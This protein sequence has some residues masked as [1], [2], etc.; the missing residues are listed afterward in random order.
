M[1]K[2]HLW[3]AIHRAGLDIVE[4]PDDGCLAQADT[5]VWRFEC[6][7]FGPGRHL[8]ATRHLPI[9]TSLLVLLGLAL[10]QRWR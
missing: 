6:H 4:W 10:R 7:D 8:L 9:L 5:L 2:D 1:P 3:Q